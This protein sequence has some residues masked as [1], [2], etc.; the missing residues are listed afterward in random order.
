M[1]E[2]EFIMVLKSIK[3]LFSKLSHGVHEASYS[4]FVKSDGVYYIGVH[5]NVGWYNSTCSY[6]YITFAEF[7]AEEKSEPIIFN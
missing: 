3:H 2:G 1:N 4:E 7:L 5:N 6:P